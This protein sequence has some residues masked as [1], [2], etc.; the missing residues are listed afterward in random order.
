MK[1]YYNEKV[2]VKAK[3]LHFPS[4]KVSISV[5][6]IVDTLQVSNQ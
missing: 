2:I 3:S 6:K 4:N 1:G 5:K